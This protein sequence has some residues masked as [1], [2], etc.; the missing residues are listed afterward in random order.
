MIMLLLYSL[1]HLPSLNSLYISVSPLGGLVLRRQPPE[2]H[3]D[4]STLARGEIIAVM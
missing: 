1:F 3:R 2:R 4:Q